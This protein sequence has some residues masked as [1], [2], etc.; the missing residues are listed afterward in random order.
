[1]KITK[2]YISLFEL[3]KLPRIHENFIKTLQGNTAKKSKEINVG[4]K[5]GTSKTYPFDDANAPKS[6]VVVNTFLSGQI[7]RS[8]TPPFLVT[9]EIFN[10]N[11]HNCMMDS[12]GS[13]NVI[14]LKVCEKKNIDIIVVDILHIHGILLRRD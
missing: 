7:S 4:E 11:V 5:K 2:A 3:M 14:P 1:L 6:Q 9:F 8:T 10:K 13:S 12:C